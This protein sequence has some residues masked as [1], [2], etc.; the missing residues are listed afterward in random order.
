MSKVLKAASLWL[1][2]L[3]VAVAL[4]VGTRGALAQSAT[5]DCPYDGQGRLGS[6]ANQTECTAKCDAVHGVGNS[7]A[8]CSGTPG[9]CTCLF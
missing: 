1:L 7:M 8:R 9:C 6:C 3:F 2:G 4:A 5:L